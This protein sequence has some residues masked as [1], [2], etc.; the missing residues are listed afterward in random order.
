MN[1]HILEVY[2]VSSSVYQIDFRLKYKLLKRKQD[3]GLASLFVGPKGTDSMV[4]GL[5]FDLSRLPRLGL[6]IHLAG[7]TTLGAL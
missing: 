4:L 5:I 2:I 6:L 7:I 3:K 1:W